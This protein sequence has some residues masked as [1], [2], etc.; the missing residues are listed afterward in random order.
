MRPI[1]DWREWVLRLKRCL[2][3]VK[4]LL[5]RPLYLFA[6]KIYMVSCGLLRFWRYL[7]ANVATVLRQYRECIATEETVIATDDTA[8]ETIVI[9]FEKIL[10]FSVWISSSSLFTLQH[11]L[12]NFDATLTFPPFF[13]RVAIFTIYSR[14]M[15][16]GNII[17]WNMRMKQ[18]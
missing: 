16:L 10:T 15:L 14:C 3:R 7:L 17:F 2:W 9:W 11:H 12:C 18:Y 8:I 4:W 13:L 6:R 1:C 5:K